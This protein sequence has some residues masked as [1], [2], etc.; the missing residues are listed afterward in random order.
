MDADGFDALSRSLGD[1]RSRRRTLSL[2]LSGTLT[3]LGLVDSDETTAKKKCPP[4][5]KRKQGKCKKKKPD[6]TACAGGTCQSGRCVATAPPTL[7][8]GGCA[9]GKIC[10]ANNSCAKACTTQG[11][12]NGAALCSCSV[13]AENP[14]VSYCRDLAGDCST[15][16]CTSTAQ[17]PQGQMCAA[18]C[19]NKCAPICPN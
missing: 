19:G 15:T 14:A 4:C 6:G 3:L 10:L 9:A 17:C 12:C 13:T 8:C 16:P 1:A 11:E 5:K 7:P 2:A 18:V